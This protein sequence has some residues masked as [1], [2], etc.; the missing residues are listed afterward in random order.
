MF[1]SHFSYLPSTPFMCPFFSSS[2]GPLDVEQNGSTPPVAVRFLVPVA[3]RAYLTHSIFAAYRVVDIFVKNNTFLAVDENLPLTTGCPAPPFNI[4]EGIGLGVW[5][6]S[7]SAKTTPI[8]SSCRVTIHFDRVVP[9]GRLSYPS[10]IFHGV[11]AYLHPILPMSYSI[12]YL[13]IR[14]EAVTCHLSA[15]QSKTLEKLERVFRMTSFWTDSGLVAAPPLTIVY[16]SVHLLQIFVTFL[17]KP[18]PG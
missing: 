7:P 6:R 3:S 5:D 14:L 17:S 13:V 11:I 9:A 2:S 18:I 15:N 8:F 16:I 10:S 1:S 12:Q 4:S